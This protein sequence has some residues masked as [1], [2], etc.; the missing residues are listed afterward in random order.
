[1]DV[2]PLFS[3]PCCAN[4]MQRPMLLNCAHT[5]CGPCLDCLHRSDIDTCPVC[6]DPAGV[7]VLN[8]ALSNYLES[9]QMPPTDTAAETDRTN[10]PD[11]Q[12]QDQL[13]AKR[14]CLA[15]PTAENAGLYMAQAKT[16]LDQFNQ[17]RT[18]CLHQEEAFAAAVD[19]VVAQVKVAA[20]SAKGKFRKDAA[21]VMKGLELA[22]V[23]AEIHAAQ[24][25]F[26]NKATPAPLCPTDEPRLSV[27]DL[28]LTLA[29][30]W[31]GPVITIKATNDY[32]ER[33]F[34]SGRLAADPETA[35][36]FLLNK[37][38]KHTVHPNLA[39][40]FQAIRFELMHNVVTTMAG[41]HVYSL[42]SAKAVYDP[43]ADL[44]SFHTKVGMDNLN[45]WHDTPHTYTFTMHQVAQHLLH[46]PDS[47]VTM[48][49]ETPPTTT[50]TL[51][52]PPLA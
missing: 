35:V 20:T 15:K 50:W 28:K 23:A 52:A 19:D 10:Q 29:Q 49:F 1:M 34:E 25:G 45:V 43:V 37:S 42:S 13:S 11:Q 6:L 2:N 33:V 18:L 31:T 40:A 22:Q 39:D 4:S 27:H 9:M 48:R 5:I 26:H 30:G 21:T 17:Y 36:R 47:A 7:P 12:D 8:V 44:V 16:A 14:Q 3:C 41:Q 51:A 46:S 32:D 24:A 38:S